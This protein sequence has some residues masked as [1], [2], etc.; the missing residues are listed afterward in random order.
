MQVV[1]QGTGAEFVFQT[2]GL[3]RQ[4]R[5]AQ[6]GQSQILFTINIL[7]LRW[8]V[9]GEKLTDHGKYP[10]VTD[11][12]LLNVYVKGIPADGRAEGESHQMIIYKQGSASQFKFLI[13][14]KEQA[15]G[16]LLF[17]QLNAVLMRLGAP[18]SFQPK[19]FVKQ[20]GSKC[21]IMI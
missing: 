20:V 7:I 12:S 2:Q 1:G 19:A 5:L 6:S 14:I 3:V 18:N 9:L 16:I 4:L 13:V 8:K 10:L 11:V 21:F 15:D 17:T